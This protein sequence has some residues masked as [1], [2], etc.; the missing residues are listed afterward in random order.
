MRTWAT[1]DAATDSQIVLIINNNGRDDLLHH[2]FFDTKQT[3]LEKGR[4]NL[5]EIKDVGPM[6][7]ENLYPPSIRV[8]IRGGDQWEPEDFFVFGEENGSP[9]PLALA[10]KITKVL[11]TDPDDG[12]GDAR[13]SIPIPPLILGN[14]TTTIYG[15]LVLMLT[16]AEG[17]HSQ[18]QLSIGT[19]AGF[20][21]VF[22]MPPPPAVPPKSAQGNQLHQA[23]NEAAFYYV[24]EETGNAVFPFTKSELGLSI[25]LTLQ[26]NDKWLPK[27]FFIFGID[28]K[29]EEAGLIR[30]V[31]LVHMPEWNLGTLAGP[32]PVQLPLI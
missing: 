25:N 26:G 2:T 29:E 17:T 16:S 5:Y 20:K 31:P 28:T 1:K 4:S 11:S 32:T 8:G 7:I 12:G 14:D 3:D 18:V 15:L 24:E 27:S 21:V 6:N 22:D 30:I 19:S 23:A 13:L 9:I 10:R